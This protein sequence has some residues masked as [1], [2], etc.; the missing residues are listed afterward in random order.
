M[1][2]TL[3]RAAGR[4]A[5]GAGIGTVIAQESGADVELRPIGTQHAV[6]PG[7]R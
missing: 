1:A 6:R 5:A 7:G 3:N 4:P 2:P